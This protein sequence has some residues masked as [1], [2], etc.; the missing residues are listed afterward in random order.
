MVRFTQYYVCV[1]MLCHTKCLGGANMLEKLLHSVL[2]KIAIDSSKNIFARL[3]NWFKLR[4]VLKD[5]ERNIIWS[6][7][8]EHDT[9]SFSI[10][11]MKAFFEGSID[12]IRRGDENE[13]ANRRDSILNVL[14]S[15]NEVQ[16]KYAINIFCIFCETIHKF[17]LD[18]F[19]EEAQT[20]IKVSKENKDE[21]INNANKSANE[22]TEAVISHINNRFG[23]VMTYGGRYVQSSTNISSSSLIDLMS[24]MCKAVVQSEK[25]LKTIRRL[26]VHLNEPAIFFPEYHGNLHVNNVLEISRMLIMNP[27]ILSEYDYELLFLSIYIHDIALL[28]NEAQFIELVE[29]DFWKTKWNVYL[30]TAKNWSDKK[31]NEIYNQKM[32]FKRPNLSSIDEYDKKIIGEFLRMHHHEIAEFI[33]GNELNG[34][35]YLSEYSQNDK[36]IIGLI[37]K[38]HGFKLRDLDS[39]LL[40]Q[41]QLYKPNKCPI[42]YLMAVMRLADYLDVSEE[43][44]PH[45]LYDN[46]GNPIHISVDEWKWNQAFCRNASFDF[47]SVP[48]T[49]FINITNCDIITNAKQFSIIELWI[50]FVQTELDLAWAYMLQCYRGD[51]NRTKGGYYISLHCINT[52]IEDKRKKLNEKFYT[53]PVSLKINPEISKLLIAPLYGNRPDYGLRELLQN[54]VDACR[55]RESM[56]INEPD[57]YSPYSLGDKASNP[58]NDATLKAQII[59]DVDEEKKCFVISDN[60]VGMTIDVILNYFTTIGASFRDCENWKET[61]IRESNLPNFSRTGRFGIGVLASFLIGRQITVTTRH[62][63][64]DKE[65]GYTFKLSIDDGFIDITRC[66]PSFDFG[67]R[68]EIEMEDYYDFEFRFIYRNENEDDYSNLWKWYNFE[69]PEVIYNGKNKND[70]INKKN[71]WCIDVGYGT[72]YML[73]KAENSD[74]YYQPLV[75]VNGFLIPKARTL[76]RG[77][78]IS[79]IDKGNQVGLS[80]N[81]DEINEYPSMEKVYLD[82]GKRILARILSLDTSSIPLS[83]N[84]ILSF[85]VHSDNE[86]S[87]LIN[88]F[89]INKSCFVAKGSKYGIKD[90]FLQDKE[91]YVFT[92]KSMRRAFFEFKCLITKYKLFKR[93]PRDPYERIKMFPEAFIDLKIYMDNKWLEDNVPYVFDESWVESILARK[94][95][96]TPEVIISQTNIT[97]TI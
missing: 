68:I 2:V 37:A 19:G 34:I 96:N 31:V 30:A 17:Q 1:F 47:E 71:A 72:E 62:V 54:A 35:M 40:K 41:H 43:R 89:K 38:S 77:F 27:N 39:T 73:V 52:D 26:D 18:C 86:L 36:E 64:D 60:G 59:I 66:K 80:L 22:T 33:C 4:A 42:V 84:S 11:S 51:Y 56:Y 13:I 94:R 61:H 8:R 50:R 55:E 49:L 81:R 67:T 10:D 91:R 21:I 25:F 53:K 6:N 58:I 88:I 44:A 90:E 95:N 23:N 87:D 48:H 7:A 78:D 74:R 93:I 79:I 76:V 24:Q 63:S 3:L 5:I 69:Y 15:A 12:I 75:Y 82:I 97:S 46:D 14:S 92:E 70:F 65:M 32:I 28:F 20:I 45:F 57:K 9:D 83:E 29:H 16:K 85:T